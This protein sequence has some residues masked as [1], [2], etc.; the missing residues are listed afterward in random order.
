MSAQY[1][2]GVLQMSFLDF[3]I[4]KIEDVHYTACGMICQSAPYIYPQS[5]RVS[6]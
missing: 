1:Y 2:V 4:C 6:W 3:D 5:R